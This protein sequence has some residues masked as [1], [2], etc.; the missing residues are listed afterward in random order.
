MLPDG[1]IN[2]AASNVT[3]ITKISNILYLNGRPLQSVKISTALGEFSAWLHGLD[4]KIVLLAHNAKFDAKH[5]HRALENN[6]LGSSFGIVIGFAD[7]LQFFRSNYPVLKGKCSLMKLYEYFIGGLYKAH[8]AL[9]DVKPLKRILEHCR[10]SLK[11]LLSFSFTFSWLT[12]NYSFF[13]AARRRLS[14]LSTL[15]NQN[16]LSKGMAN[17]I[18]KSGLE[19]AH[20]EAVYNRNNEKHNAITR[21]LSERFKG[22]IRVTNNK[23][24]IC[25]LVKWLEMKTKL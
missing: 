7:S 4:K 3:G 10:I 18:A 22:K 1:Q 20:L 17:K 15:I 8:N 19:L 13:N 25:G 24:V 9:A 21:L 5:L 6:G 11:E 14:T 2:S 16:I 23:K 12:E